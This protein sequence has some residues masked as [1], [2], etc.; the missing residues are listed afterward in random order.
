M[1]IQR[2]ADSHNGRTEDEWLQFEIKDILPAG[3]GG[4]LILSYRL[5]HPAPGWFNRPVDRNIQ[6]NQYGDDHSQKQVIV[7]L[8]RNKLTQELG[9]A[10]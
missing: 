1:G 9:D 3:L 7:I 6:D 10:I 2:A 5:Q 4:Y 8:R